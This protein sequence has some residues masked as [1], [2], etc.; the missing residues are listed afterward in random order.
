MAIN[1]AGHVASTIVGL[2][3][4]SCIGIFSVGFGAGY[5]LGKRRERKHPSNPSSSLYGDKTVLQ[6]RK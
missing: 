1:T 3:T 2:A 5:V 6:H 4:V